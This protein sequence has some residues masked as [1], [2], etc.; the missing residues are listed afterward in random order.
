MNDRKNLLFNSHCV[1]KE[2]EV[3]DSQY[4]N[5]TTRVSR[6][7]FKLYFLLARIMMLQLIWLG[8]LGKCKFV[9]LNCDVEV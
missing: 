4:Q 6:G 1:F 5:N 2:N 7:D 9:I 8:K 3:L